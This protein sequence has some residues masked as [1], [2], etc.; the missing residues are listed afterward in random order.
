MG[1]AG[2]M[3]G[4]VIG[5]PGDLENAVLALQ[6]CEILEPFFVLVKAGELD[7]R[8]QRLCHSKFLQYYK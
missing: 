4:A 5:L 2:V 7:V 3:H 1:H 8:S 6:I